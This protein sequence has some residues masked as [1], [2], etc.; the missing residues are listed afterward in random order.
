MLACYDSAL[1]NLDDAE[2]GPVRAFE[3]KKDLR[4]VA[5]DEADLAPLWASL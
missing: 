3:L 1:G 4:L 5:L 2:E